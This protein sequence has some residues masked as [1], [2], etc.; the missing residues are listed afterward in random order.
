LDTELIGCLS[1]HDFPCARNTPQRLDSY[2]E[3]KAKIERRAARLLAAMDDPGRSILFCAIS[4]A[5]RIGT[6]GTGAVTN[7]RD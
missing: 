4:A 7:I 2:P 1:V 5:R 6:A 3:F